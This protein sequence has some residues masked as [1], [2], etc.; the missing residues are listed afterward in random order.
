MCPAYDWYY[1]Q[2]WQR[3]A[4]R[5]VVAAAWSQVVG[6][7]AK[8]CSTALPCFPIPCPPSHKT[9]SDAAAEYK[10]YKKIVESGPLLEVSAELEAILSCISHLQRLYRQLPLWVS[11]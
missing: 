11:L 7:L 2:H 5:G 9:G 8:S 3:T 10:K 4:P 1:G 6:F